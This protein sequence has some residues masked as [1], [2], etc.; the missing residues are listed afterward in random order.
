YRLLAQAA[1]QAGA[2]HVAT[3]HTRDDQAETVLIR[4]SRGSGIAGLA[5]M[6]RL[7]SMPGAPGLTLGR[8]L[9]EIAKTRLGATPQ[10]GKDP[11]AEDP[12]NRDP[13]FTRA[14]LRGLM[15]ALAEE[16]FDA[17]R[18]AVLAQRARRA[19]AALE[20]AVDRAERDLAVEMPGGLGI[21]ARR[22][23]ALPA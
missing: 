5:A 3:A 2:T 17:R 13:R 22:Y 15:P 7:S 8:P 18:L 10:A 12:S 19:D 14:R 20:A 23:A 6:S 21:E 16:G 9:L 1:R 4:M 11:F